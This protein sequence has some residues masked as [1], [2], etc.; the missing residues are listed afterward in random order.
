MRWFPL[1]TRG[2]GRSGPSE[3]FVCSVVVA[4]RRLLQQLIIDGKKPIGRL[5]HCR[6]IECARIVE[7]HS[8]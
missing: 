1:E 6:R 7:P 2:S 4:C 3:G 8:E 5:F